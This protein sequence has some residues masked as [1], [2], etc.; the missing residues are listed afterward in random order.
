MALYNL[1][2][3]DQHAVLGTWYKNKLFKKAISNT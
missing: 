2:A 3:A 1:C